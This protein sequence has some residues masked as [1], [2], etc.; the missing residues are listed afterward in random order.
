[1]FDLVMLVPLG[2]ILALSIPLIVTDTKEHR[3]PNKYTIP[4]IAVTYLSTLVHL[5]ATRELDPYLRSV[6]LGLITFAIG[7]LLAR[8][9]DLGMGDV[10]LLT[11]LNAMLAWHSV[12]LVIISLV[13]GLVSASILGLVHWIKHRDPKARIALGPFLFIGF[14]FAI[15][16]PTLELLTVVGVS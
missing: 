14:L 16:K 4:A 10:K 11:S 7:Y 15:G 9:L 1:M 3:L 13:V 8:F 2:F 12:E 6:I 5:V